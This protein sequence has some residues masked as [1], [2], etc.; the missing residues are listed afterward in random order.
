MAHC[1]MRLD[2]D[3]T[4]HLN[5]FGTYYGPQ[6]HHWGRARDQI[7][8]TYTL[9]TPQGKSIAPAYN[10]NSETALLELLV[11]DG[12]QPD[13]KLL[14]E[15]NGLADGAVANAPDCTALLPF[16][17]DNVLLHDAK[18][19]AVDVHKL[20]NPILTGLSGNLGKYLTRGVRA[21][22]HIIAAQIRAGRK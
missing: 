11:F 19:E 10:D 4:V 15:L 5:P 17:R 12:S 2:E 6:R 20:R 18:A 1:P 21:I 16:Y 8:D 22:G 13:Q 14:Q 3:G 7:L 9:V